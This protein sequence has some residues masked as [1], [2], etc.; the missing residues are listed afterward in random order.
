MTIIEGN[1]LDAKADAI[2]HQVNCQ[3][4]MGSGL[5]KQIRDRFPVVYQYY[6]AWCG[7]VHYNPP[8][9]LKSPLLGKVQVVYPDDPPVGTPPKL[10]AIVN[11]F[12][13]NKFGRNGCYT[14]YE[15]L[16]KC[17][18]QVNEI[19]HGRTVALP[20]KMSCG[21]GGGD[22]RTV[23]GIIEQELKD[24]EVLIYMLRNTNGGIK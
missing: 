21:L 11:L 19:F 23:V 7:D 13:Q 6:K 5:A 18:R 2:L 4:V 8:G 20:Y 10:P 16:R 3:G 24:C 17:L 14:D 1:L 9:F 12:A 22:W 15:A